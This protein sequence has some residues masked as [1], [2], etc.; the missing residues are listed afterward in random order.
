MP[1]EFL[2]KMFTVLVRRLSCFNHDVQT[3]MWSFYGCHNSRSNTAR[4]F[5][6]SSNQELLDR[7]KLI[8]ES[9][10]ID[11]EFQKYEAAGTSS[12]FKGLTKRMV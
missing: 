6:F 12:D 1:E 9:G 10:S 2:K 4:F 5:D 8:D 7:I 3:E 11:V